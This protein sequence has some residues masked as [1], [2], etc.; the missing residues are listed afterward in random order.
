MT[1][2]E[3]EKEML[4]IDNVFSSNLQANRPSIIQ[5]M[6]AIRSM[7]KMTNDIASKCF[8]SC[9][10]LE[11]KIPK[12]PLNSNQEHCIETCTLNILKAKMILAKHLQQNVDEV[13][14]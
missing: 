5:Q 12:T 10:E 6:T 11:K 14:N 3:K 1:G 8:E 7:Y 4:I 13:E 9:F 2:E